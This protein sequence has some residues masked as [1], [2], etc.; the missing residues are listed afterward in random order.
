M[1]LINAILDSVV[2]SIRGMMKSI[3]VALNRITR[4]KLSPSFITVSS[5]L[6][7]IPIAWLIAFDKYELAAVLLV[8]F[9]LFDALDGELARLQKKADSRGM[10]LDS[11]TD[12][13]KEVLLYSGVAYSI[14]SSR[15]D[16]AFWAVLAC[17]GSLLVSYIRARGE[18]AMFADG[19]LS[20]REINKVFND[21]IMRFEV[22]IFVLIV[23]LISGRVILAT[24][25]VAILASLTALGRLIT[26]SKRLHVQG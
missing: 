4:G 16:M 25:L 15:P 18:T 1:R 17:G 11:T 20:P 24:I 13:M 23:G 26:V 12:R 5:L 3:A 6:M 19:K 2:L 7:H 10:L 9:G 22:R 21:G 14:T 8:I